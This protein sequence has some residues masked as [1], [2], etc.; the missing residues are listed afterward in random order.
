MPGVVI[1]LKNLYY[2][3]LT[4]DPVGGKTTYG[5]PVRLAGAISANINPNPSKSTLFA[6]D[7][8]MEVA[9]TLG[10]IELELNLADIADSE[11]AKLLGHTLNAKGVM[12]KKAGDT[13]I[14]VAVGFESTKSNGKSKYVWLT[15]GKFEEPEQNNE[16]KGDSV[17]FKTPTIK[18]SFVKRDSDD[19]WQLQIDA[20]T[21][22][23]DQAV[24]TGWFNAVYDP[25]AV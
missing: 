16:T 10:Q 13:P 19:L 12:L 7:G 3:P 9:S 8:P 21:Q 6:D 18:A 17:N 24:I 15:K 22:A 1:G 11:L 5:A 2:A 14:W 4:V 23:A 20:D 25:T